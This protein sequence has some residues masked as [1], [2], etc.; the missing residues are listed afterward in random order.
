MAGVAGKERL[1]LGDRPLAPNLQAQGWEGPAQDDIVNAR[2]WSLRLEDIRQ[3]VD[4]W[5]GDVDKNIQP[6]HAYC[7]HARLPNSRLTVWE[8]EAHLALMV[9]WRDVLAALTKN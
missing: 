8:G 9:H 6:H 2:P 1:D 7:L 3:R 4:I 5:Q